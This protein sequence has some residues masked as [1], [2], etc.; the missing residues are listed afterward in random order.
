[1]HNA[2]E[3]CPFCDGRDAA[4]TGELMDANPYAAPDSDAAKG[5]VDW[6]SS[7]HGMWSCGWLAEKHFRSPDGISDLGV[8]HIALA[9]SRLRREA[10][11]LARGLLG[12]TVAELEARGIGRNRLRFVRGEYQP[13]LMDGLVHAWLDDDERVGR[14]QFG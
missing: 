14:T 3:A 2:D 9:R 7:D 1:M 4:Q 11:W 8:R 5:S 10:E 6:W 13:R 12:K